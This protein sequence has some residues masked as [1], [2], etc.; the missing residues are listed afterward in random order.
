MMNNSLLS[1]TQLVA[2]ELKLFH[3]INSTNSLQEK[4]IKEDSAF[5]LFDS[6]LFHYFFILFC[7]RISF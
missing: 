2:S 3:G 6:I 7:H 5:D 4:L 1:F